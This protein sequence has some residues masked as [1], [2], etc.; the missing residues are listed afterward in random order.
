MTFGLI[1]FIIVISAHVAENAFDPYI[2]PTL[3]FPGF[4]RIAP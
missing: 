1:D 2:D 3:E 4:D